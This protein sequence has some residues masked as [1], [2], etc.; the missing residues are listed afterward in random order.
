MNTAKALLKVTAFVTRPSEA[1]HDLLLFQ[2][3][4]AGI[5]IPAGTVEPG[6][7]PQAAALRE[8]REE[9]GLEGLIVTEYLG[10]EE[11]TLPDDQRVTRGEATVYARP[12]ATSFDWARLRRGIQVAA[13]RHAAGFTQVRYEE[14]DRLPDPTYTSMCILGW[15]ADERLTGRVQRHFFRLEFQGSSPDRW[16]VSTDNHIFEP[17]WAPLDDLPPVIPP[18]DGWLVFLRDG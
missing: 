14:P 3:P 7:R 2:H 12:D 11:K 5:Q 1:G 17:F 9:S 6:E 8:A 13:L 18:Q 15:V 4:N 16:T 10:V